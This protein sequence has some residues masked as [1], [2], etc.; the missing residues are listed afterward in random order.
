[1]Q[2]IWRREGRKEY[3]LFI[4]SANRVNSLNNSGSRTWSF[5]TALA[6][7]KTFQEAV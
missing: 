5:L 1:M 3:I 6:V 7:I 4:L 2:R